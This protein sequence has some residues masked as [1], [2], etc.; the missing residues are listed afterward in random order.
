MPSDRTDHPGTSGGPWDR[1]GIPMIYY[2]IYDV[3]HSILLNFK[4]NTATLEQIHG[5]N[6]GK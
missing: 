1:C 6:P 4:K 5:A 3:F 2:S